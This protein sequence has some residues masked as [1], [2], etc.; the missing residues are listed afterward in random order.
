MHNPFRR[1]ARNGAP[2][3]RV[4]APPSAETPMP[5]PWVAIPIPRPSG[6]GSLESQLAEAR[7]QNDAMNVEVA[8]LMGEND[9]LRH[10]INALTSPDFLVALIALR[11][12][13]EQ[14]VAVPDAFTAFNQATAAIAKAKGETE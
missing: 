11:R 9:R 13:F 1:A 6:L 3:M 2:D 5:A 8:K 7:R 4:T 10:R 12:E 14:V